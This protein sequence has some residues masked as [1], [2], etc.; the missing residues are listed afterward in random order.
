[1]R[2]IHLANV[3]STNIGN[4]ALIYGTERVISEDLGVSVEFIREAWDDYTFGL[5]KF[6]ESFVDFVNKTG[7]AL[8]IN[9]AVTFNIFRKSNKNTGM[10]F[11]LPLHLWDKI[12]VP[13]IFYGN[14]YRAWPEQIYENR[15]ILRKA[16]EFILSKENILF[17]VRNDGT[18]EWIEEIIGRKSEK[19]YEIVD[20]G[21]YT[22]ASAQG[23]YPE[24]GRGKKNVVIAFNNEDDIY[25]FGGP[26]REF[27]WKIFASFLPENFLEKFFRMTGITERRRRHFLRELARFVEQLAK[28]YPKIQFIL[29]AHYLDDYSMIGEFIS[30]LKE[31]VAH[32][33]TVSTGLLKTE[34]TPYFYGRYKYVDLVLAMRIHSMSPC[35]GLGIPV[36]PLTYPGRMT[37]FLERGGLS[38]I[39]VGIFGPDFCEKLSERAHFALEKSDALKEKLNRA[40]KNLREK[41]RIFNTQKLRPFLERQTENK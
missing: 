24:I 32:Q 19:I 37:A 39:Q 4:G 12:K 7:D 30:I 5:K 16:I 41:T 27:L 1:M 11:D 3:N 35:I 33:L 2:I 31:R 20:P 26:V 13:I 21:L 34:Q 14:S 15:E 9:G 17:G 25:R 29:A 28:K 8:L 38:E 10:R 6:D 18:K 23:D 40:T 36:I 22:P